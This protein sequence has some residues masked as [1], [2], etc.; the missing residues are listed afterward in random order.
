VRL[1]VPG[2]AGNNWTKWVRRIVVAREESPS[3]YMQT[4]YRMP[5]TPVPAGAAPASV[6]ADPVTWMNVKSLIA[7][8]A[9]GGELPAGPNEIRGVAWTGQGHITKVDVRIDD[10]DRW[11][12]ASLL[13]DADPGA[14]RQWS[15][16]WEPPR[17][18]RHTITVRASDSMGQVQPESPPW[19][20]SG[21][22]WNGFDTVEFEVR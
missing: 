12:S 10:E 18:G 6:P 5:R 14:W 7:A 11:H 17:K 20:K 9:R 4:A 15:L 3:F 8:P 19:N 13:G 2:W 1:V 16:N 21:Y 22:L